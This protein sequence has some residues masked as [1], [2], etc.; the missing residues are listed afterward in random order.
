MQAATAVYLFIWKWSFIPWNKKTKPWV[1]PMS[2][3]GTYLD[4]S[5]PL[6][7]PWSQTPDAPFS[8][9]L[10]SVSAQEARGAQCDQSDCRGATAPPLR[11]WTLLPLHHP[12][13]TP[14]LRS[15]PSPRPLIPSS[16]D[17]RFTP[18]TAA[19]LPLIHIQAIVNPYLC[20]SG[21]CWWM[22][23]DLSQCQDFPQFGTQ[24]VHLS[25]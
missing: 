19:R 15:A 22:M 21:L 20:R 12:P 9:S 8:L 25:I 7:S 23:L 2:V 24:K 5:N 10:A 14:D 6:L 3:H 11:V 1:C 13:K 16:S 17:P 4:R 18:S